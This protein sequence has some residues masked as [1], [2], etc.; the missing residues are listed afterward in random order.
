MGLDRFNKTPCGFCFVEYYRRADTEDAV[1][2][3]NGMR[4]DERVARSDWSVRELACSTRCI[5]LC[6]KVLHSQ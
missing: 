5:S 1:R 4:L 3:L 6:K 2:F